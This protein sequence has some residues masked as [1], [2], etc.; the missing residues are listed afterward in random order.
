MDDD[1]RPGGRAEAPTL[2]PDDE[3]VESFMQKRWRCP[4]CRRSYSK[5]ASI[6]GHMAACLR[7]P[8]LRTCASCKHD[9]RGDMYEGYPSYCALDLRGEERIR[10]D[11]PS[12]ERPSW[13]T[14]PMEPPR[15]DEEAEAGRRAHE[16]LLLIRAEAVL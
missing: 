11:C 1:T 10:F 7:R 8:R 13:A 9:E 15:P 14:G 12:W 5:R 6:L 2:P 4:W 16:G 3:L